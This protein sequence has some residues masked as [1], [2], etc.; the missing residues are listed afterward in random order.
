MR[1]TPLKPGKGLRKHAGPTVTRSEHPEARAEARIERLRSQGVSVRA[2]V[3]GGSCSGVAVEKEAPVR[4]EAYRRLVAALPCM[5]C[6]APGPNQCAHSNAGKGMGIK[7]C[8]LESF[9]LCPTCHRE[10][11]QGAMFTKDRRRVIEA[12]WAAR[13]RAEIAG[14]GLWPAHV[15]RREES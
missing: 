2:A 9:S 6:A 14:A 13:T 10:F 12:G 4:S 15:P 11:D 8:D 5:R 1:R 7:S 3:M